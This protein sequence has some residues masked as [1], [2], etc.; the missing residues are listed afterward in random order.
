[1]LGRFGLICP[2]DRIEQFNTVTLVLEFST[3]AAGQLLR[4]KQPQCQGW[5][6]DILCFEPHLCLSQHALA[7]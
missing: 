2:T 6:R 7:L 5:G 3:V 4:P 1:M